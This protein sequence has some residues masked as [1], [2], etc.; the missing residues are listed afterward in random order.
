MM[1]LV[2][3]NIFLEVLLGQ[4]KRE[5]CKN[6]LRKNLDKICISDFT[7]HSMGVILFKNHKEDIFKNFAADLLNKIQ[8]FGLSKESYLYLP[9]VKKNFNLDFDD[10]YQY[11]IAKEQELELVTMDSDWVRLFCDNQI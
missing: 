5:V 7:L 8:I 1:Y 6:F 10:A 9:E 2:D 11:Y 3:T 4:N